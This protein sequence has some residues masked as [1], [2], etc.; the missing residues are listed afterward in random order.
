MRRPL[1]AQGFR[2]RP[3]HPREDKAAVAALAGL[4][5]WLGGGRGRGSGGWGRL[6]ARRGEL[7]RKR[8][9]NQAGDK[10]RS[11]LAG[12]REPRWKIPREEAAAPG[13][14]L[15]PTPFF[16]AHHHPRRSSTQDAVCAMVAR[17][18]SVQRSSPV[19]TRT[20]TS[21]GLRLSRRGPGFRRHEWARGRRGILTGP[22]PTPL[23]QPC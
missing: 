8:A 15:C 13:R 22:P 21:K 17:V 2:A 3:R 23:H 9:R 11:L 18:L 1:R 20:W 16:P 14:A 12:P 5:H 10:A 19:T 7:L 6:R 4:R